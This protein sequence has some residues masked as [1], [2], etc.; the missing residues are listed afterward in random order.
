[1]DY[2]KTCQ[3]LLLGNTQVGKT[4]IIQRYV[5]GIF[6]ETYVSTVGIDFVRKEE[7]ID[8]INVLIKIWD[9]AGQERFKA[10]T[11]S[12]LRNAEGI[13]LVY[14][15]T[16]SDSFDD[17]KNWL[18]SVKTYYGKENLTIPI[19]IVGNKIDLE[20]SREIEKNTAIKFAKEY[21][22]KYFEVS[23]KTGEGVDDAVKE[24][25]KEILA[26][27]NDNEEETGDKNNNIQL[28]GNKGENGK[29]TGC[30]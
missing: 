11:P 20:N 4:C 5:N 23:A 6:K 9:T 19:V 15:I 17:L 25:A 22:Y 8:N 14:D 2:D 30:C 18:D 10:L 26:N 21:G 16:N 24:L 13:L 7:I 28:K 3:I 27:K 29:K 12:C 1:M